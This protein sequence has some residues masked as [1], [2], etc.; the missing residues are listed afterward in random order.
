MP[1]RTLRKVDM[2]DTGQMRPVLEPRFAVSQEYN[3]AIISVTHFNKDTSRSMLH[4]VT[5]SAVF[6]QT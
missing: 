6:A 5:G 1:G 4:R 2:N 3:L